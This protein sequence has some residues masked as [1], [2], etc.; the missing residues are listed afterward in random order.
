VV[1]GLSDPPQLVASP[2][3]PDKPLQLPLVGA[4]YPHGYVLLR[5]AGK[6]CRA[7]YFTVGGATPLYE[8]DL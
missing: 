1:A 2:R 3:Q 5:L 8:E 6:K 4:E 7:Q